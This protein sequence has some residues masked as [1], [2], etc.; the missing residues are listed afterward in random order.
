MCPHMSAMRSAET[1]AIR[2]RDFGDASTRIGRRPEQPNVLSLAPVH[3]AAVHRLQR[4]VANGVPAPAQPR[5]EFTGESGR[6][7]RDDDGNA[8]GGVRIPPFAVPTA[9]HVAETHT[10]PPDLSGV[11]IPFSDERLRARYPDRHTYLARFDEA[12]AAGLAAGFLLEPEA[13]QFR[14]SSR[15]AP[16]W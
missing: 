11:S 12:V 3:E 10:L 13:A 4:W 15:A 6:I 1:T 9:T 5:L 8:L 2:R 16:M 14:F 7:A